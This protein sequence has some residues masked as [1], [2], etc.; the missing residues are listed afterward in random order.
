[1]A[2]HKYR[3]KRASKPAKEITYLQT[4]KPKKQVEDFAFEKVEENLEPQNIHVTKRER[5]I[6]I[7]A[8]F[9]VV[10][11]LTI[12]PFIMAFIEKG[13][14]G[15]LTLLAVSGAIVLALALLILPVKI[16]EYKLQHKPAKKKKFKSINYSR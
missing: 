9:S 16:E 7:I 15:L 8:T 1:M 2:K 4:V 14:D 12:F 10:G 3:N 13:T 6:A 5:L 11:A